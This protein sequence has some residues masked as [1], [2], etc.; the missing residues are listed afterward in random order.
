[1]SEEAEVPENPTDVDS[2][3]EAIKPGDALQA[4]R[5]EK[6]LSL[7]QVAEITRVPM[8]HLKALEAND[9]SAMP[10]VT[11]A[12]GFA[13][14]YA[15]AV[16]LDEYDMGQAVRAHMGA[17][18]YGSRHE[19]FEPID[20]AR[21]PPRWLAW[22][23]AALAAL[24]A[25]GYGVW[26]NQVS[27]APS[28]AEIAD[29]AEAPAPAGKKE[30]ARP[31]AQVAPAATGPVVLTAVNEVWLR[32]YDQGG[33]RLLEKVLS[34]GESYTVPATANNP[35]ILTGRPDGLAVTVG[36]HA[37]APLGPPEK[38]ISDVQIS[39]ASL[40]AR[41]PVAAVAPANGSGATEATH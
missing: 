16:G 6:G 25:I 41:P 38:T 22:I 17:V 12:T 15:R 40:L 10:G 9:F 5:Q 39:A 24:L 32:I 28:H 19:A 14:A 35:M 13:R 2:E 30:T 37:V 20:P 1:V 7:D 11:Y 31:T 8:R 33:E 36:G 23:A 34:K 29:Q 18:S 26:R 21:I 27:S 3:V 4:A